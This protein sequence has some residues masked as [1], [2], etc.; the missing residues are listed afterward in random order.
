MEESRTLIIYG[1]LDNLNDYTR[2][3]RSNKFAGA[4][5]KKDN[6]DLIKSCILE[7]LGFLKFDGQVRLDFK[8]YEK[9]KNRDLDN[10]CFA[11]KF[12]LDALVD[13]GTIESDGWRGVIG[14]TDSFDVDKEHP[15]IEVII[16]GRIKNG[17]SKVKRDC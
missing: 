7:Q 1:R 14:F 16:E 13:V 10:I 3:C 17:K 15:R 11:K 5:L 9:N 12:I 6:E 2:A 4:Q 8:W